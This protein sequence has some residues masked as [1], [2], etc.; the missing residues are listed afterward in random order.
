[1]S[2]WLEADLNVVSEVEILIARQQEMVLGDTLTTGD[3]AH[4]LII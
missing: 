1:M 3:C 2:E 4:P